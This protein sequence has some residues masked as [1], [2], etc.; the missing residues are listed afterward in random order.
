MSTVGDKI[1]SLETTAA[2]VGATTGVV[3]G[4]GVDDLDDADVEDADVEDAD[5]E[6]ADVE[7]V[8]DAD[9][10]DAAGAVDGV[11]A[12]VEAEV[13]GTTTGAVTVVVAVGLRTVALPLKVLNP[14]KPTKRS[15]SESATF[16]DFLAS[17]AAFL[18]EEESESSAVAPVSSSITHSD[19]MRTREVRE[20]AT[21]WRTFAGVVPIAMAISSVLR[22]SI[23]HMTSAV[24]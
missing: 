23:S 16:E 4:V 7:D 11:T 18:Y 2:L 17:S 21:T 8:D 3:R 14:T 1:S 20:R 6:D 10:D 15:T 5:V 19:K 9:V 22:P 24:R 13:D 12:S